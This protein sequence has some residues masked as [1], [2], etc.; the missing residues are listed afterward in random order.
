MPGLCA[1]GK[2][3]SQSAMRGAEGLLGKI[4]K[5]F[6]YFWLL[7]LKKVGNCR[8]VYDDFRY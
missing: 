1:L 8:P 6:A 5:Y 3:D 4:S 2:L 7:F